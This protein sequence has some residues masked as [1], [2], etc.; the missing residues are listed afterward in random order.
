MPE[1]ARNAMKWWADQAKEIGA[2]QGSLGRPGR[3]MGNQLK[4]LLGKLRLAAEQGLILPDPAPPAAD[5]AQEG[6]PPGLGKVRQHIGWAGFQ[7]VP[8]RAPELHQ[9][10]R[11]LFPEGA[12]G[13]RTFQATLC[14]RGMEPAAAGPGRW[15]RVWAEGGR[16][17]LRV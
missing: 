12:K 14:K 10:L 15:K 2:P 16:F 13:A 1:Q 9:S 4:C 17:V 6:P 3:S 5:G 8:A 7:V 11:G